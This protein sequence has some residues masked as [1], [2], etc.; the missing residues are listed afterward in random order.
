MIQVHRIKGEPFW[1]NHRKIELIEQHH[2][3]I[4][5][6][7]N[8]HRFIVKENPKEIIDLIQKFEAN[9]H[10]RIKK[11]KTTNEREQ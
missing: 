2:D 4:I 6:L 8:E 7:G 3:T 1:I 11:K 9:I 5:T 10:Y